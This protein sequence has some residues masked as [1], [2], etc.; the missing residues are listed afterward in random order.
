M[1]VVG[2]GPNG[3]AAGI[4]LEEA[5]FSTKIY[6]T[7]DTIGGGMR[8]SE[9]TLPGFVHDVCSAV[10]PLAIASPYFRTLPLER[11][12]LDW[13]KPEVALA[14][15][16]DDGT[17]ALLY[18]SFED[19][20]GEFHSER[21][22]KK[23]STIIS[24]GLQNFPGLIRSILRPVTAGLP[25]FQLLSFGLKAIH[26]VHSY[27]IDNF[28]GRDVRALWGGLAAHSMLRLEDRLTTGF[29]M[30]FLIL[31]HSVGWPFPR[32]GSQSLANSMSEYFGSLGG[33]IMTGYEVKSLAALPPNKAT[34]FDVTPKQLL[35]ISGN[36]FPKN[37][38]KALRSFRY[39]PGVFKLDYA[40]DGPIPWKSQECLK[41]STVH[42][43]GEL[44]EI[45]LSE[46]T[47]WSGGISE[48]PFV[49]VTQQSL[50]DSTR[51]PGGKHTAWAYCHVPSGSPIDMTSRIENQIERFAPGFKTI[52]LAR[53]SFSPG[54]LESYNANYVG[55]DINAGVQ[56]L[57]QTVFRPTFSLSP[58]KTPLK[59]I[60]LC[61]SS[62]PP[63]G[64][65]HGMCGFY[66]AKAAI[67]EEL[68]N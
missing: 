51:A 57:R 36:A 54:E 8:S 14:N 56:N 4:L 55:G 33:E 41:A 62:T 49:I 68:S 40:L 58:Y 17:C 50:F 29:A 6:E 26:P 45:A 39:G 60:Y 10:H 67:A 21:D 19:T 61:S 63:G 7:S 28:E 27:V 30:I 46:R 16:F 35:K 44:D 38:A 1:I 53:H 32:G 5:N 24:P 3:L 64:G 43:C 13:I 12:G 65:V 52:I 34:L 22:R 31:A 42:V 25:S 18:N 66:A 23:Y 47:V 59:G 2:S 20:Q 37:Y 15:P 48:R 9:L 11:Y